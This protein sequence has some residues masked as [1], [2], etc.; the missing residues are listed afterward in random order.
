[1][2][3]LHML[4][5]QDAAARDRASQKSLQNTCMIEVFSFFV[6]T[7]G[8]EGTESWATYFTPFQQNQLPLVLKFNIQHVP[9]CREHTRNEE[10]EAKH[11]TIL[12]VN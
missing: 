7:N 3:Q 6:L 11:E 1:M 10:Q 2:A 4:D 8:Q 12:K 5:I 9:D